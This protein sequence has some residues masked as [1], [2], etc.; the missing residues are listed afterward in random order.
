MVPLFFEDPE[1]RLTMVW[2]EPTQGC[3]QPQCAVLE[4]P[5]YILVSPCRLLACF[6]FVIDPLDSDAA[7]YATRTLS[8]TQ[9]SHLATVFLSAV[10]LVGKLYVLFLFIADFYLPSAA[11]ALLGSSY[12][13]NKN[14]GYLHS[15]LGFRCVG[16]LE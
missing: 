7:L 13:M 9:E 16:D 5:P 4:P 8:Y 3:G 1:S 12:T 11:K 2:E 6:V 10:S 14:R 15:C